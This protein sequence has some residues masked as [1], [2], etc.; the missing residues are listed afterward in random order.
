MNLRQ[1]TAVIYQFSEDFSRNVLGNGTETY[2]DF[3][4]RDTCYRN[5]IRPGLKLAIT[6]RYM[7]S[8]DSYRSLM[9]GFRVPHNTIC[10]LIPDVCRAVI[11]AYSAQVIACPTTQDEWLE[12]AQQFG[13]RWIFHNALGAIDGKHIAIKALKNSVSV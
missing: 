12:V 10:L 1:K 4:K 8:C 9:Y 2:C 7:A 11:D 13:A 5:V 3:D 6:L